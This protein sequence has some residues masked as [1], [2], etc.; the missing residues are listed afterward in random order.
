MVVKTKSGEYFGLVDPTGM[1]T[2]NWDDLP[3]GR[4]IMVH[5]YGMMYGTSSAQI[6]IITKK[7]RRDS[8]ELQE[9]QLATKEQVV[10]LFTNKQEDFMSTS[11]N[12][13]KSA[14]VSGIAGVEEQIKAEVGAA[15][16]RALWVA[17][18][19]DEFAAIPI[20]QELSAKYCGTTI[21]TD[22]T[23][24]EKDGKV[25][26]LSKGEKVDDRVWAAILKKVSKIGGITKSTANRAECIISKK[27]ADV[28][29]KAVKAVAGITV[30]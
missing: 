18:K 13:I 5:K 17:E 2:E 29:I 6:E 3:D 7:F 11:A 4:P 9:G 15:I 20:L 22:T 10:N 16:K 30:E 1:V 12:L 24:T 26:K 27:E 23:L 8:L 21:K 25:V 19:N 28:F 14:T